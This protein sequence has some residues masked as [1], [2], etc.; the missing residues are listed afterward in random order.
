MLPPMSAM[1]MRIAST[2][3]G[4]SMSAYGPV[5]SVM[6]PIFTTSSEIWA[7]AGAAPQRL[8]AT[9]QASSEDGTT[10]FMSD[11]SSFNEWMGWS[12]PDSLRADSKH[13]V[14]RCLEQSLH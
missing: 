12:D 9:R 2:P 11:V 6:N 7:D 5:M 8:P 14:D 10:R 1:A 3:P 13:Q 4:P